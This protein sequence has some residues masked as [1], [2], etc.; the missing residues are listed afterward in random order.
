MLYKDFVHCTRNSRFD[1][2]FCRFV[3]K[4]IGLSGLIPLQISSQLF[5]VE[6][7]GGGGG[8]QNEKDFFTNKNKRMKI[9]MGEQ[10][11]VVVLCL[12]GG[13]VQNKKKKTGLGVPLSTTLLPFFFLEDERAEEKN[14]CLWRG[15]S[16]AA[17]SVFAN[18]LSLL[19][20]PSAHTH[21]HALHFFIHSPT[22]K[23]FGGEIGAGERTRERESDIQF[24]LSRKIG[25]A[26]CP[27]GIFHHFFL[28]LASEVFSTIFRNIFCGGLMKSSAL[29]FCFW[30]SRAVNPSLV[31][32]FFL[33]SSS[34][35]LILGKQ[36]LA[37]LF[38][39]LNGVFF[40][41]FA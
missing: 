3:Y 39:F 2:P 23:Y 16:S 34:F 5:F 19:S 31:F 10:C 29:A 38:N 8:C 32:H 28:F 22:H 40:Q 37:M 1:A 13:R 15:S 14:L 21:T 30:W 12:I 25:S 36:S 26:E 41:I 27:T 18:I 6:E 4:Y 35:L 17:K 33:Y 24:A 20:L 9:K 11:C 7:E